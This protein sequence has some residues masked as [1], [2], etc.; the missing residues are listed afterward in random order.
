[1]IE[2]TNIARISRFMKVAYRKNKLSS[3]NI[4]DSFVPITPKVLEQ[5][6]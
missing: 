1:M 2:A 5:Q 4:R 3:K 6:T